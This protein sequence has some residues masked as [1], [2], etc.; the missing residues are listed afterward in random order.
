MTL[1]SIIKNL[2]KYETYLN[3]GP[4]S[5]YLTKFRLSAH[6]LPIERGRYHKP[7]IPRQ[8]RTCTKCKTGIG[9]EWHVLF[10]CQDLDIK[11]FRDKYLSD[12]TIISPQI[13]QLSDKNKFIY[14][15]KASDTDIISLTCDWLQQI[16]NSFK[17]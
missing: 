16:D 15:L 9:D 2:C 7:K 13:S 14:I 12:I 10:I 4:K 6:N 8:L 11:A 5:K 1:Y 17:Y 3:V